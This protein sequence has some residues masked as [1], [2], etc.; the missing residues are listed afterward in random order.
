MCHI[1]NMSDLL[2]YKVLSAEVRIRDDGIPIY[3]VKEPSLDRREQE[4]LDFLFK[5]FYVDVNIRD[6]SDLV[7]DL[8]EYEITQESY[9]KIL[10]FIKK[11]FLYGDLTVPILDPDVEEIECR[12]YGF[13]LTIVHRKIDRYP[14]IFSNIVFKTEEDVINVI[15]SLANKAD[16]SVSLAR[17]FLE[18]S[19]PEGHRVASTISKE[20][21]LPGSTFDIRKF[22]F[23]PISAISL[24]K[25]G[26]FTS[27]FL[28]F[29]WY[30]LEFKPFIMILGPTGTGKTTFLNALLGM[31]NPMAK[32]ITIEDTPE[33][34]LVKDNWVRFFS[35]NTVQSSYDVS[36][37]DLSRLALRYRPDYLVIG[38]V[39]GKEIEA[40]VH[41]SA[42]GHGSMATFHAGT[43][44]EAITRISSLLTPEMAR[45]FLQNLWGLAVLGSRKDKNGLNKRVLVSFYETYVERKRVKFKKVFSWSSDSETT[46]PLTIET[47]LKTSYRLNFISRTFGSSFDEIRKELERRVSFIQQMV[48]DNI[49]SSEEVALLIKKFYFGDEN[50]K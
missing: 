14:R 31:V 22:P 50:V 11:K 15:E 30:L 12:G 13:P 40:L 46:V 18:F 47:L 42:S 25:N 45:L 33:I 29:I 28:A 41:A 27:L 9:E 44:S 16:K 2:S 24:L 5:K 35:R 8:S 1:E 21:S 3:E 4:I 34:S 6:F 48:E 10:Y 20:I 26:V 17:P 43:P 36:L 32:I 38:E 37:F 23:S 19:L 49:S 39:R 7:K